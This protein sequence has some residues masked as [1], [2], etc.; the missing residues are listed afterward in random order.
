M[1]ELKCFGKMPLCE[2]GIA[3]I[4]KPELTNVYIFY[5]VSLAYRCIDIL[6]HF[7]CVSALV[8]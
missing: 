6:H 5:G 8:I 7:V 3:D 2:S 4:Y 1:G